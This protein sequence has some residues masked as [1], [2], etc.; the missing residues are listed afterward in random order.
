MLALA[1]SEAPAQSL[2][3]AGPA[4]DIASVAKSAGIDLTAKPIGTS[5]YATATVQAPLR[6]AT[7][8]VTLASA[9]GFTSAR[10]TTAATPSGGTLTVDPL[11]R[12]VPAGW[13]PS[14]MAALS[15]MLS[16]LVAASST[17]P[18]DPQMNC[19]A[20]AVYFEARGEP[21]EGQL[22]VA[23]VVINRAASG[24]YPSDWCSVVKQKAQFS[25]VRHGQFPSVDVGCEAW[26]RAQTV[27]RVAAGR[28]LTALPG[29]VL[30]YHADYVAPTWGQRLTRV[31]KIGAHIFYRA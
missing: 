1:S 5:G 3:Q 8:T 14:S 23:N 6:P 21:I 2:P 15:S 28:I 29:D 17:G 9:T 16:S 19:L 25:F 18:L 13:A 30:W 11:L 12:M 20:T 22:A 27:A 7:G 4:F 24:R 10:I 26:Q 31:E